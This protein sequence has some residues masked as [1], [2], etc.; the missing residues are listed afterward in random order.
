MGGGQPAKGTPFIG[1]SFDR[2]AQGCVIK[3]ITPDSPAEKA[4]LKVDDVILKA[5]GKDLASGDDL[6]AAVRLKTPGAKMVLSVKRG[7]QMLSLTVEI[8]KR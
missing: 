3:Q 7:D 2:D 5:D 4:G 6:A 8:G 1:V